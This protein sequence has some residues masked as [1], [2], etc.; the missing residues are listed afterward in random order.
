[1]GTFITILGVLLM[2]RQDQ[3]NGIGSGSV[4]YGSGLKDSSSAPLYYGAAAPMDFED[5]EDAALLA[6]EVMEGAGGR[7]SGRGD[8]VGSG[9]GRGMS[10]G[11]GGGGGG[12]GVFGDAAEFVASHAP[13]VGLAASMTS[14]P[15]GADEDVAARGMR[16]ESGSAEAQRALSSTA[17]AEGWVRLSHGDSKQSFLEI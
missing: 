8:G 14:T 7:S 1:V 13:G 6:S 17:A 12:G 4:S 15:A 5:Y 3:F 9:G 10:Y 11:G 16:R 2:M